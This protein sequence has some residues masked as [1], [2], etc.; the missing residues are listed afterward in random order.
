MRTLDAAGLDRV[1][2]YRSLVDALDEAFRADITV[3]PRLH[4]TIPVEDGADITQLLMPAW[5]GRDY[6]GVKLVNVAPD[7]AG[8]GLPAVQAT[9]Q[10][11]SRETGEALAL[12]DG[13]KLTARKTAAASALASRYLSRADATKLLMVGTGV[14]APHL[15]DAH[16]AV[17]PIKEVAVWGR[18]PENAALVEARLERTDLEVRVVDD[19]DQAIPDADV[20]SCATL[21]TEPLI[22]GELLA[23]GQH[24]DLVGAFT[25]D[26]RES[27]D[28]CVKRAR[29]YVDTSEAVDKAG[30]ICDPLGRGVISKGDIV[31]DLFDLA[32][33]RIEGRGGAQE[34][35][36]FKSAGSALL[37]LATAALA[38]ERA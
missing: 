34:I 22:R 19:L 37:D 10:L 5:D 18:H 24:L 30:D 13:N 15:I 32:G 16:A 12:L 21:A 33:G 3:P 35:T 20:I 26:M 31:G 9:Y 14:M 1:L 28:A 27:D 6:I 4:L 38:Y 17:R 2:D 29:L 8:R 36:L 11:F 23:D 7:N 25:P